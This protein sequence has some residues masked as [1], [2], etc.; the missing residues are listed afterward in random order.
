MKHKPNKKHPWK[1][2]YIKDQG[3]AEKE[4]ERR[5]NDVRQGLYKL[6]SITKSASIKEHNV[7]TSLRPGY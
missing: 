3:I 5:P 6:Q 2:G 7:Y 4:R 1:Q